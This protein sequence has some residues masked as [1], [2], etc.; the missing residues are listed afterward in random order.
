MDVKQSVTSVSVTIYVPED[1]HT[2]LS[3]IAADTGR[4]IPDLAQAAFALGF[5]KLSCIKKLIKKLP[6]G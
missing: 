6:K 2:A 1:V 4:S 5:P 3:V